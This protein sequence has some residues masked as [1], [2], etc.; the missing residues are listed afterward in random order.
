MA[1]TATVAE[2]RETRATM[3]K[4]M[5]ETGMDREEK[6]KRHEGTGRRDSRRCADYLYSACINSVGW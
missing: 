3:E 6:V 5:V 4:R 2:R 1:E